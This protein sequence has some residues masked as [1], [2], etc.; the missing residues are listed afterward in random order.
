MKYFKALTQTLFAFLVFESVPVRSRNNINAPEIRCLPND[1]N[2]C[3][4]KFTDGSGII[5]LTSL[6]IKDN[7]PR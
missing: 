4:C 2:G 7:T 3:T 5:D 6:G 1:N